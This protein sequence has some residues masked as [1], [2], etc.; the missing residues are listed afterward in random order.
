ME[1]LYKLW[2]KAGSLKQKGRQSL[3]SDDLFIF[4]IFNV[5]VITE[6]VDF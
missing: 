1:G 3:S 4:N 2:E 5:F 6:I